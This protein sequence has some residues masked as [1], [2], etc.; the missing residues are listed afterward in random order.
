MVRRLGQG[1]IE[2][3]CD[4]LLPLQCVISLCR[5]P[6]NTLNSAA[7]GSDRPVCVEASSPPLLVFQP[8]LEPPLNRKSALPPPRVW[9]TSHPMYLKESDVSVP[10][11][12]T[13]SDPNFENRFYL[14]MTPST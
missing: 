3:G 13:G 9:S 10:E 12:L 5:H 11:A 7:V 8:S 6:E 4:V 14:T 2:F 1:V